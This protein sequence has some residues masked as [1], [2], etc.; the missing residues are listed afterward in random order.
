MHAQTKHTCTNTMP[1][2]CQLQSPSL[3]EEPMVSHT[4]TDIYMQYTRNYALYQYKH[5]TTVH[6]QLPLIFATPQSSKHRTSRAESA[7]LH[8][9]LT[10][11]IHTAAV[12]LCN[13]TT[14]HTNIPE[15]SSNNNQ[16]HVVNIYSG[17][18]IFGEHHYIHLKPIIRMNIYSHTTIFV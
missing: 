16:P 6:F 1:I 15:L 12:D 17:L 2:A 8:I 18:C 11:Y 9:Y 10:M 14:M 13:T 7:K 4:H 3:V 5:T